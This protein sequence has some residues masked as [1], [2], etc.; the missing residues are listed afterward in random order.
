MRCMRLV[1]VMI[2]LCSSVGFAQDLT[3][4]AIPNKWLDP[5]L[6]E[7]LPKLTY[8][9]YA[10]A[11][12]R[13]RMEIDGGRYKLGLATLKKATSEDP[14][15]VAVLKAKA[16]AQTGRREQAIEALSQ[17]AIANDARVQILKADVLVELGKIDDALA[18]TKDHLKQHADSIAGHYELGRIAELK[19]D[20]DTAREAYKWFVDD[21]QRFL[22]RA[23]NDSFKTDSA[24]DVTYIG[25][26]LDRWA[27][28]NGSY[29]TNE[30]LHETILGVFTHAYDVVDRRYLP[31]H[32]AAAEYFLTH[33]N[34]QEAGNE[35]GQVLQANPNSTEA[36]DLFGQIV[37]GQFNFDKADAIVAMIRHIDPDSIRAD[38]LE[39]R[40]LLHQ[41]RPADAEAPIN[42]ASKKQ[43]NNIEALGLGASAAAL[44]LHDDQCKAILKQI[45]TINPHNASAY[46]E[47][48]E[49]LSAMRQYPRAAEMYKVA[50][51]R[52]PGGTPRETD[53][54]F[55]TRKA[56]TRITHERPW[57]R[58]IRSIHST[59]AHQLSAPAR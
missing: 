4:D 14:A 16:L 26:G 39:A 52:A 57:K 54:A 36:L 27:T 28:L 19:G 18:T 22:D 2:L 5:L 50:I 37:I 31:A 53:L 46:L 42:R 30:T 34:D 44:R 25:R 6:P 9:S 59:C 35:L 33:D 11:L 1:F 45:D 29:Q 7:D 41:R 40:N 17:P 49:Q 48:A 47:L 21:P 23:A 20:Y 32:I 55:S 24:E 8:P 43:P 15:Q 13:A 12:D 51:E 10:T 3:R 38:L 58:H 56:A